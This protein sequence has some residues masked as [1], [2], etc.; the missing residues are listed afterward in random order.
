TPSLNA[1]GATVPAGRRCPTQTPTPA[2]ATPLVAGPVQPAL[3][4]GLGGIGLRALAQLRRQLTL[5][6][7]RPDELPYLRLLGLDGD[8]EALQAAGAGEPGHALQSS[9]LLT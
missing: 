7:G 4:L 2:L 6:L 1:G 3:I 8:P 5:E 9:E